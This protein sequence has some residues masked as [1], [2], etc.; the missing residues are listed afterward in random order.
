MTLPPERDEPSS[1]FDLLPIGAYRSRPEGTL[2]RA[3]PAFVRMNGYATEA[4]FLAAVRDLGRQWYVDPARRA[5]LLALLERDGQIRG[6]LSEVQRVADGQRQWV[7][8]NAHVLRDA[9]G[10]LL[11]IEGTVEDVTDRVLAARALEASERRLREIT[12]QVPG[13]VYRMHIAPDGTRRF[14][15]V[16]EGVRALYGVTPAQVLA[17]VE[18]LR[19]HDHPDDHVRVATLS[20]AA[21]AAG[22]TVNTEFRIVAADG[23]LKWV[24]L[25]SSPVPSDEP[26]SARVGVLVDVT[27]RRDAERRLQERDERWTLALDS[28]GDGRWEVDLVNGREVVSAGLLQMYGLDP[29]DHD[30]RPEALDALTQPDDRERM[31]ADRERHYAGLTPVYVNEH[32]MRCRDGRWKWVLS[33]GIVIERDA[34]GR[35]LRMMGTHTDISERKE[36]EGLR[37][38]RDRGAA[39]QKAQSEFLSRVSHELR[40]PLNAVIGFAQ[41]LAM[42]KVGDERQRQWVQTI[43]D[44]GSHLLALVND[45]LDLSSLQTGKLSITLQA[46]DL[47]ALAR[48]AVQL[49]QAGADEAG[50][51]VVDR[52]PAPGQCI[53]QADPTRL[54]QVLN[55][56]LSNAIKYNRNGGQVTLEAEDDG[57]HHAFLIGDEGLG[58]DEAQLARLFNPFERL[59]AQHSTI[60]GTGLGLALTRHLVEAMGGT[61]A[62]RSSPGRGTTFTVKL[63]AVRT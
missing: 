57:V 35:P 61:I 38:E 26:G 45:L 19:R 18:L 47:P 11:C 22:T 59:G 49:Q 42:D 52:L 12:A 36:A 6:T 16:S 62:V 31:E 23:T 25:A 50:V 40:T 9:E 1:L 54:R 21:R 17:D 2:I 46:V 8:E 48:E 5:E 55:N 28:L 53:V 63:S 29:A 37:A 58:M 24:Q 10:R 7:S 20:A 32:R 13:V 3:N 43:I 39:A 27:A 15:Y 4:E 34:A 30:G 51:R 14:T 56:L 44:S 41:L 60:A 33:R